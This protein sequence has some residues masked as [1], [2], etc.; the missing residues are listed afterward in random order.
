[1]F[2]F[3]VAYEPW[4]P[5]CKLTMRSEPASEMTDEPAPYMTHCEFCIDP[6]VPIVSG[7]ERLVRA[8]LFCFR[9][10]SGHPRIH[11]LNRG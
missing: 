5:I 8:S 2:L 1:M 10:F 4:R 3:P 7:V 9:G 11:L 6:A